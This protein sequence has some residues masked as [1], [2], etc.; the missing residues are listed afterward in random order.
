MRNFR[1]NDLVFRNKWQRRRGTAKYFH[2]D[3][4][5]INTM[6]CMNLVWILS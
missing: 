1:A 6:Q 4:T 3:L 5:D 2:R